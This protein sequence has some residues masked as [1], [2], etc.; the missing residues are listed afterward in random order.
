MNKILLSI[1]IL[2]LAQFSFAG[3]HEVGEKPSKTIIGYDTTEG[4]K[5]PIYVGDLSTIDIWVDYVQAHNDRDLETIRN[6]NADD[7]E[8]QAPNGHKIDG[9]DAH[10]AFLTEWFAN[11]D[12]KW[13]HMYSIANDFTG[14]D[15]KLQQWVTTEWQVS[16][17]ID[18]KQVNSQDVFDVLIEGGKIK[19]IYVTTRPILSAE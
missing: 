3:H 19:S 17:V 15:G 10:V 18:G 6:T 14:K 12:P 1:S 4:T 11:S 9:P 13:T 16:D 5:I 7:F 2:L 8:G